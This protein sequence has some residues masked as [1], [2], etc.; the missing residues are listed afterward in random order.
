MVELKKK[1][2]VM[3]MTMEDLFDD[4]NIVM[5]CP[6]CGVKS[7]HKYLNKIYGSYEFYVV[8]KSR[9][10]EGHIQS[11]YKSN[12]QG[13]DAIQCVSCGNYSIYYHGKMIYPIDS[14]VP[15]LNE[16]MPDNVKSVYY[17]AKTVLNISPKSA[18]ALLRLALE[19][20]LDELEIAGRSLNDKI[21]K[22]CND[23]DSNNRLIKAF[24]LVRLV[25]NEAVHPGVIDIDDNEDIARAMFEIINEIVDETITKKNKMDAIFEYLPEEKT[26]PIKFKR[27]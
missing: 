1:W 19:M 4:C 15:N 5:F 18:C 12:L 25:G 6:H 9:P 3:V 21:N 14:N 13:F 22:Y 23:F 20:L 17:E 26:N 16:D 8:P 11:R 2:I 24:H 10:G 7:Q 27:R